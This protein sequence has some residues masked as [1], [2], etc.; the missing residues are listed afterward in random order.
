MDNN[1]GQLLEKIARAQQ[2]A[3]RRGDSLWFRG[4]SNAEWTLRSRLHRYVDACAPHVAGPMTPERKRRI[5][6]EE[7][8]SRYHQFRSRAWPLLEPHHRGAWSVVFVM[9]HEGIGTRLLDW[10]ESFAC[11]LYFAQ[12]GRQ[13]KDDAALFILN[14]DRLNELS[15][16]E[17]AVFA[18]DDDLSDHTKTARL[19][20]PGI[21]PPQNDLPT[22]AITPLLT[23][24]RMVAQQ[25]TFVLMGDS[26]SPL[27][28]EYPAAITKVVLSAACFDHVE[29]YLRVIGIRHDTYF[30]DLEGIAHHFLT[31]EDETTARLRK[32]WKTDD[33]A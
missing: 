3:V 6:R 31:R 33:K 19:H 13:P 27:E 18:V 29:E 20:H 30:P 23:H 7:Y 10:T 16:G 26:F 15:V 22:I 28:Q 21:V 5:L 9:Q 12:L 17:S 2:D 11:A 25:S 8:K 32:Q 24:P 14:P 4:Q 1:F